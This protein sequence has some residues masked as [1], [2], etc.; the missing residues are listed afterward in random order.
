MFPTSGHRLGPPRPPLE[1]P[2]GR[3][4]AGGLRGPDGGPRSLVP[5]AGDRPGAL[6]LPGRRDVSSSPPVAASRDGRS[7]AT[8]RRHAGVLGPVDCV[9]GSSFGAPGGI[10]AGAGRGCEGDDGGSGLRRRW[11]WWRGRSVTFLGSRGT[12]SVGA[13][14]GGAGALRRRPG[15][16]GRMDGMGCLC[17]VLR[18]GREDVLGLG[19]RGSRCGDGGWDLGFGSGGGGDEDQ[20]RSAGVAVSMV[21][22]GGVGGKR[23]GWRM[24]TVG[25]EACGCVFG[26]LPSC[27]VHFHACS[28]R[29]MFFVAYG[30]LRLPLVWIVT[31][32][33]PSSIV[34]GL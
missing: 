29:V 25:L 17:G 11:T 8:V 14:W 12:L 21:V 33:F 15:G 32:F 22:H 28:L 23:G 34:D 1:V 9:R 19:N 30:C 7:A 2:P 20:V 31:R 16:G 18:G 6:S 24:V 10:V 5:A 26:F 27:T 3:M 4:R 13:N